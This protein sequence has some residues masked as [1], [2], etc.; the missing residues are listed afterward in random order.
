VT[1]LAYLAFVALAI[2]GPGVALQRLLRL[3]IDPALVVTAGLV[4]SA[5]AAWASFASGRHWLFPALVLLADAGLLTPLGPWQRAESP[6]LRGAWP[7]VIAIVVVLA[8][9]QYPLNRID[10]NGDFVLDDLERIDTAF[11]VAVTWEITN[12]WPPQVPGLAGVPLHY[13]LGP[14]LIRAAAWR[15]AGIAPYDAMYRFDVTLW[16]IGLV[17]A[18]RAAAR[19]LGGGSFAI[20]LAGFTPLLA[21]FSFA[22]AGNPNSRWW[23]ELMGGNLM[24]SLLFAN[25]LVPAL[26][27]ALGAIL[28][29]GRARAGEGRGWLLLAATL[30]AAV[31]FFKVFLVAPLAV[32]LAA[33]LVLCGSPGT[34]LAVA[35]PC[36]LATAALVLGSGTPL[37]IL[38]DPLA[39]V[40]HTRHLLG[41]PLLEGAPLLRFAVPWLAA[42]LGL[43]LLALPGALRALGSRSLAPV[44][45]GSMALVGWPV[46]LLFR[47]S[48]DRE[49]NEAVYFTVQSGALLWLFAALALE[50][51]ALCGVRSGLLLVAAAAVSLPATAELVVRKALSPP[52]VVPARVLEAMA[53]LVGDSRPGDVVLMRPYSR[54]PPPPVVFAGRRVPYTIYLPYMRQFAPPALLHARSE[55]VR[56]F[57]RSDDPAQARRVAADLHARHVFV[58]GPQAIGPGVRAILE[59]IYVKKDT[60]LYRIRALAPE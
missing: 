48:A 50:R 44:V 42:A 6:S 34:L 53:A 17:L 33:A 8:V 20:A 22:F 11:H 38:L 36:L 10:A 9:T 39:P 18:L 49:F 54:F 14:H 24:L 26:A 37:E 28:A 7:A 23:P 12:S 31:P 56:S 3:R 25:S 30:A 41:L 1:V 60:G 2:V 43:R 46:A 57:F 47:L 5:L 27:L 40:A 21:D 4:F 19:A 13:H 16:A 15:W 59:P 45:L 29:L 55:Q 35:V 58:H 52:D 51:L 32:G